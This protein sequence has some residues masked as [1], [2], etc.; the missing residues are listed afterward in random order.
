MHLS[1]MHQR[2]VVL[3]LFGVALRRP[4]FW[5]VTSASI[6]AVGLWLLLCGLAAR[7]DAGMSRADL[8]S[9]LAVIWLSVIGARVGLDPTRSWAAAGLQCGACMLTALTLQALL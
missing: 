1:Q 9:L 3:N 5:E 7:M 6:L 8:A 2:A 4:G